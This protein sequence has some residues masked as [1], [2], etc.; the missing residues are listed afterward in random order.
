MSQCLTEMLGLGL[1]Y[2][3]MKGKV[4]IKEA[5]ATDMVT[6]GTIREL[7]VLVPVCLL[8]LFQMTFT[9]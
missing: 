9:M 6:R 5:K 7:R 2:F 3:K 8:F 4:I 1:G